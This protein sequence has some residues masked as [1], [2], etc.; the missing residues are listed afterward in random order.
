MPYAYKI[1]IRLIVKTTAQSIIMIYICQHKYHSGLFVLP[2]VGGE[3]G[4]YT[5][6]IKDIC[7]RITETSPI[8][9]CIPQ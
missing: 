3:L 2:I 1:D 6:I 5:H 7:Q 9:Q 8:I 4:L